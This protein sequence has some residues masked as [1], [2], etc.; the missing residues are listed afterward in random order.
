MSTSAGDEPDHDVLPFETWRRKSASSPA[1]GT[2]ARVRT[3]PRFI[4]NTAPAPR[5]SW[6]AVSR[7]KKPSEPSLAKNTHA[8]CFFVRRL[9]TSMSSSMSNIAIGPI[10]A[11]SER[12]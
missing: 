3:D 10:S 6:S 4:Q 7:K 11:P 1:H 8:A 12:P 5:P 2:D 9:L